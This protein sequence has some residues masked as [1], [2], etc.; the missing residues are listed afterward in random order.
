MQCS[1]QYANTV[2]PL[3]GNRAFPYNYAYADRQTDEVAMNQ[4]L[5]ENLYALLFSIVRTDGS[6]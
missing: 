6:V 4:A 5:D 2:A 1:S 3:G